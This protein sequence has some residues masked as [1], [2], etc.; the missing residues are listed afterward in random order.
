MK[1]IYLPN[2]KIIFNGMEGTLEN[3]NEQYLIFV[4]SICGFDVSKYDY[5][6]SL[7]DN[8]AGHLL[9]LKGNT[10]YLYKCGSGLP[11]IP[12]SE[13]IGTLDS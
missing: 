4:D 1:I 6:Y 9:L 11:I 3:K 7:K 2:N 5:I 13:R 10:Y 8:W 12:G